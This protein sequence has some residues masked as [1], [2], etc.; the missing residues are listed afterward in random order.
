[1]RYA[2]DI[3]RVVGADGI[4]INL[5]MEPSE[6]RNLPHDGLDIHNKYRL[7]IAGKL[8]RKWAFSKLIEFINDIEDNAK[9]IHFTNQYSR[10]FR[11]D[12]ITQIVS[13]QDSPSYRE[14]LSPIN[15]IHTVNLY[16]SMQDIRYILTNT[17]TLRLELLDRGYTGLVQSIHLPI[18][19]GFHILSVDREKLRS[20]LGLPKNK[21]L[22]LSVSSDL[23]R[24]NLAM[25]RSVMEKLGSDYKLVRVGPPVGDSITFSKISDDF[26]NELYNASDILLFPSLYEGFGLP[27][28]EAFATGLPVVTSN[29]DTIREVAGDC[30]ILSDPKDL[31]SV[32]SGVQEAL[33][34]SDEL[35]KQGLR[36]AQ[37]FR[38]EVFS[39]R[40]KRF[41][42]SIARQS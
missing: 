37:M 42:E 25:V 23:P 17:E 19:E 36:R 35:S 8:L 4:L 33:K 29:V 10:P 28:V 27:I 31:N 26:L 30:A 15:W 9:I 39:E 38:F 3:M 18:P 14:T 13:I 32:L 40:I 1:M 41:Y 20:Q 12:G 21:K 22:I 2:R 34:R 7:E 24:K 6:W 16:K 5:L 11:I